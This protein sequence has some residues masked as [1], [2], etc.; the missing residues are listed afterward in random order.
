MRV[1]TAIAF[2]SSLVIGSTNALLSQEETKTIDQLYQDAINEG[3][4]LVLYHG[5][6]TPTQQDALKA[7]F[8]AAFP[9]INLTLVVDYSKYH[10]VRVD[11]QLE[12]NSLVPDVVALQTLQDFP[13]WKEEGKLLHYRPANFSKINDIFKDPNGAWFGYIVFGFTYGSNATTLGS[14]SAPV[15]PLDLTD[16][17]YKGLIASSYPHDDDAVLFLFAK[18]VE[19][20]GWEWAAKFAAQDVSFNRGSNTAGELVAA[21]KKAISVGGGGDVSP[22][23]AGNYPFLVWGQRIAIMKKA[24]NVAAAKLLV[25]WLLTEDSQKKHGFMGWGVRNDIAPW[26]GQTKQVWDVP[27]ANL[28]EFAKFMEDRER[29][30][31]WKQIFALYFGEVQGAPSPGVLGLYPGRS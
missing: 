5:G 2:F 27:H 18:Y 4:K 26:N 22:A 8:N 3:G 12:T 21:G 9:K 31:M 23:I 6:D 14:L 15:T 25:N 17:K 10:N 29:V 7:S 16:P 1:L 28:A 11:N 19:K 30:E 20:Y 13:R 24:K